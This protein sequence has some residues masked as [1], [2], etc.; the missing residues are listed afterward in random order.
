[1]RSIRSKVILVTTIV[2]LVSLSVVTSIF[3][4]MSIKSTEKTLK[5]VLSETA[6]TGSENCH[7]SFSAAKNVLSELGVNK[8]LS[9]TEEGEK[10]ALLKDVKEKYDYISMDVLDAV[11]LDNAGKNLSN[12][13]FF[14]RS[15]AGESYMSAPIISS[16]KN[17]AHIVISAPIWK[18]G[19]RNSEIIG[20]VYGIKDATYL[21]DIASSMLIGE[22]GY[23]YIADGRGTTIGDEDYSLVLAEENSIVELE[24]DPELADIVALEQKAI[25]G[26]AGFAKAYYDGDTYFFMTVPIEDTDN[27][28]YGILITYEEV[29][30]DALNTL[31][32]GVGVSIAAIILGALALGIFANGLAIP[33]RKMQAA[34]DTVSQGNMDVQIDY[35][36]KDEIGLMADSLRSM[37]DTNK[38]I[39]GD[40]IFVMSEIARGNL[41][42]QTTASYI[43]GFDQIKKHI[44]ALLASLT[45][46]IYNI[47]K[48]ADQ[49]NDGAGHV[50]SGAQSLSQSSTEQAASVQELSAVIAEIS[51]QIKTTAD[52]TV[53]SG[54]IAGDA[55]R[56]IERSNLSMDQMVHSMNDITGKSSEIG[57]II[58]TIDDIAF[59]TN[60]LALNA[61]VEAERAGA[62]GRGFAVVADEVRNLAQKSAEA[63]KNTT[64]LIEGTMKSVGDGN[65][66]A[67]E[68]ADH[69]KTV[70]GKFHQVYKN[71][72]KIAEATTAQAQSITQITRGIDQISVAVQANS[73]TSEESAAASEELNAQA[74]ILKDAVAGFTLPENREPLRL[75][76]NQ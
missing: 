25:N 75:E 66:I 24:N 23:G 18:D 17:S 70:V 51:G 49:V 29:M 67:A 21:S 37:M 9:A 55:E 50:A 3:G 13:E 28:Y 72:E 62:A 14:G 7:N 32:L 35:Q 38:E 47:Q 76:H 65:K 20:V 2:L 34:V 33:I 63:A 30:A 5:M 59:Q 44:D 57:K 4:I 15:M 54:K 12:E 1:M 11:G 68:T 27:W 45:K 22:S 39:I 69:L 74:T 61:A 16:D 64:A 43:G 46:T 31:K 58:K 36:S 56:D 6:K 26:E 60:I 19:K 8:L 52:N 48:S 71:I 41:C 40:I 73:A 10:A 42:V 53:E